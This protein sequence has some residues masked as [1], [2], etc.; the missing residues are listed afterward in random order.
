MKIE[1]LRE[2]KTRFSRYKKDLSKTGSVV[3]TKKQPALRPLVPVTE[4]TDPED[5]ALSRVT[6]WWAQKVTKHGVAADAA[7]S[8]K[9]ITPS[10][11]LS[12]DPRL[13]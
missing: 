1:D 13:M 3:I 4:D 10:A 2:V 12:D 6:L 8:G 7:W 11:S 9:S 5:L